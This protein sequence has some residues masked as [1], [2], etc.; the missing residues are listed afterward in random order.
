MVGREGGGEDDSRWSKLHQD[1]ETERG[2]GETTLPPPLPSHVVQ[3]RII[4]INIAIS[5]KFVKKE[6]IVHK[7]IISTNMA[8]Q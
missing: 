7:S 6:N 8:L 2:V 5:A 1:L 3:T 4:E